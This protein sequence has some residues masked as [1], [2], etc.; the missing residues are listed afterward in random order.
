M[1]FSCMDALI[2]FKEKK[3]QQIALLSQSQKDILPNLSIPV[4][5]ISA[6]HIE[7]FNSPGNYFCLWC[8]VGTNIIIFYID[9]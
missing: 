3:Q 1:S 8:E 7:D 4:C 9:N 5:K 6:F 2:L